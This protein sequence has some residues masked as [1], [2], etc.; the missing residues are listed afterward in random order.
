M[1]TGEYYVPCNQSEYKATTKYI[2]KTHEMSGH[3]SI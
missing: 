2:L 1:R 3:E